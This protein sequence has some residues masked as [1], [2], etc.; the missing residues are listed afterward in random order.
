MLVVG[1]ELD[2]T[3]LWLHVLMQRGLAVRT[4]FFSLVGWRDPEAGEGQGLP[5]RLP[6]VQRLHHLCRDRAYHPAE[7]RRAEEG[8]RC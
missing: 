8:S 3:I 5:K 1:Y 4:E 6:G 2:S 7:P